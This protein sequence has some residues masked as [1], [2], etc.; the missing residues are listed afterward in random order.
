MI[1]DIT[2]HFEMQRNDETVSQWEWT[3][4][5]GWQNVL[6]CLCCLLFFQLLKAKRAALTRLIVPLLLSVP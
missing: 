4:L 2:S 3:S 1:D 5:C 6:C